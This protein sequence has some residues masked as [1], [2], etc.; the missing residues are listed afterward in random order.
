MRLFMAVP[1]TPSV[2]ASDI[3]GPEISLSSHDGVLVLNTR[4]VALQKNRTLS[5]QYFCRV[6]VQCELA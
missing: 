5:S 3:G 1:M 2:A 6:K 4:I